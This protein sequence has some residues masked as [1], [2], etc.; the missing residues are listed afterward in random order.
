MQLNSAISF[1]IAKNNVT[2]IPVEPHRLARLHT[3]SSHWAGF[4]ASSQELRDG[5]IVPDL[6]TLVSAPALHL[7]LVQ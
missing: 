4:Q 7:R 6:A 2:E 1:T 3:A 5:G